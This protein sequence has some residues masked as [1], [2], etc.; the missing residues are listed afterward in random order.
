M[1]GRN[2]GRVAL[3]TGASRGLGRVI[4]LR[5]A[6]SGFAVAANYRNSEAEAAEVADAIRAGGGRAAVLQA[7]MASE[8]EARSLVERVESALGP[9]S[10]VIANAGITRDRLL[11]QMSEED[12]LSTW[13]TDLAGPRALC[14]AAVESMRSTGGRVVTVS[15]VVGSTGNAGQSNYAAAKAAL[16][17][18]TREL[19]VIGAPHDVT[20]NCV[21]PGFFDTA[22]TAHLTPEQKA[23]WISRIPMNRE[24]ALEDVATLVDFLVGPHAGYIT[25]Q[26][27]AVDGGYLARLGGGLQS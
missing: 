15:S 11:L 22:A 16:Q 8:V 13:S 21:V 9:V 26:C 12:W 6:G 4:A 3:V 5:L 24:G 2:V 23:A 1:T 25:G 17:G 7:D 18:L 10:A 27:I 14:R 20:V 19:A